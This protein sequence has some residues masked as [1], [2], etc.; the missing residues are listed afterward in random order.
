MT[1]I[2]GA[3]V[4]SVPLS[5][6]ASRVRW[7]TLARAGLFLIPEEI[8]PPLELRDLEELRASASP[9]T[10][11]C[12]PPSIPAATPCTAPSPRRADPAARRSPPSAAPSR[13]ARL[14]YGPAAL[15]AAQRR[16]L[17]RDPRVLAELH[18]AVWVCPMPT[19]RAAGASARSAAR[20][21]RP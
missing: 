17:L 11:S 21:R 6:L 3:L 10:A 14:E 9:T 18:D 19:G 4:L 15:S 5:V 20:R 8:D 2:I 1:P 7:A 12:A 13:C 16:I